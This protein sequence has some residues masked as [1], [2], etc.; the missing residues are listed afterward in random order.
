MPTVYTVNGYEVLALPDQCWTCR[1]P[2]TR[3]FLIPDTSIVGFSP[4]DVDTAS[5]IAR[6]KGFS[7]VTGP[8]RQQFSVALDGVISVNDTDSIQLYIK[9]SW[10]LTNQGDILISILQCDG[11]VS[12]QGN[13]RRGHKLAS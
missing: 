10:Q 3:I 7:L 13:Q 9:R 12:V 5:R 11:A 8:I 6:D 2:V 1:S 4:P